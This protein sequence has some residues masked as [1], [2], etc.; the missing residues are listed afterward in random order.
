MQC[1]P[2]FFPLYIVHV[3]EDVVTAAQSA[4]YF[5]HFFFRLF[6]RCKSGSSLSV[7]ILWLALQAF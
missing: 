5:F 6:F 7:G 1:S 2:P 3:S 4:V